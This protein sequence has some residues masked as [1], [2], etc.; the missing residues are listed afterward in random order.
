MIDI[1]RDKVHANNFII[2]WFIILKN[3]IIKLISY[4]KKKLKKWKEEKKIKI[5]GIRIYIDTIETLYK[6]KYK[7]PLKSILTSFKM[8]KSCYGAFQN[9][10][11]C[12]NN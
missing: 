9:Q 5:R 7:L 6:R 12:W 4:K 2:V 3:Y 1:L 8:I 11:Y 10:S